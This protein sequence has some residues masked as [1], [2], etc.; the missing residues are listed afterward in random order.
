MLWHHGPLLTQPN[1]RV[2]RN[3]D[4]STWRKTDYTPGRRLRA[5][6]WRK[7]NFVAPSWPVRQKALQG[8][9]RVASDA[10]LAESVLSDGVD[11]D[12]MISLIQA[13]KWLRTT[14]ILESLYDRLA[15]VR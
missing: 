6:S 12:V 3:A 9:R 2:L 5:R 11:L 14:R 1:T 10:P 4:G 15:T 13:K 8:V 7:H